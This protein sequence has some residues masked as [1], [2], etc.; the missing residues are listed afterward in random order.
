MTS[1][2]K[3]AAKSVLITTGFAAAGAGLAG[4]AYAG[5]GGGTTGNVSMPRGH[6]VDAPPGTCAN[7]AAVLGAPYTACFGGARAASTPAGFGLASS[8]FVALAIGAL[9]AGA[10]A[11]KLASRRPRTRKARKAD[12]RNGEVSA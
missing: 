7:T 2:A 4:V 6:Q 10:A 8:S 11:I 1:W 5:T 12:T 3:W 9:M